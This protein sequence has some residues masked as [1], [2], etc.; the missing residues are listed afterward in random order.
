MEVSAEDF[1]L[2]T[3]RPKTNLTP[4]TA[5]EKGSQF[6]A[7]MKDDR[8]LLGTSDK[9]IMSTVFSMKPTD[10]PPVNQ[11]SKIGPKLSVF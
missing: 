5:N 10:T 9:Q 4:N 3:K 2:H 11:P 8:S 6:T 1:Q 7:T